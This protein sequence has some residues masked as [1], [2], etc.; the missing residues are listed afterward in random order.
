MTLRAVRVFTAMPVTATAQSPTDMELSGE[1]SDVEMIHDD[2]TGIDPEEDD[3]DDDEP[4]PEEV[5]PT[6]MA[7]RRA[8]SLPFAGR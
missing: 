4:E 5:S 3:D 6:A 1:G 7:L 2:D 8:H